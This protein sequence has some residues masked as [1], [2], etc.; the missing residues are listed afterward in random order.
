MTLITRES[1][2]AFY[3]AKRIAVIGASRDKRKYGRQLFETLLQKGF[4]A[5]AVN[6]SADRLGEHPCHHSI[7]EVAQPLDTAI[8][9]VPPAE[10]ERVVRECAAAGI[11]HLW[12]HEHVMKGLSNP[13]AITLCEEHGIEVISGY[14]PF[15]FMP[16]PGFPH[17]LH[18]WVTRICGAQ[19]R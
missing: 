18:G 14:C 17:N 15:M 11:K 3:R 9:V 5:V 8:A 12:I 19:P 10:Q 13:K 16:H 6:P 4:D 1:I 7:T 2:D